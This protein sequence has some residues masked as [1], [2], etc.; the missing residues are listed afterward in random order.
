MPP[1]ALP[2]VCS[3]PVNNILVFAIVRFKERIVVAAF[4][5]HPAIFINAFC[6]SCPAL[7]NSLLPIANEPRMRIT[8]GFSLSINCKAFKI[9]SSKNLKPSAKRWCP[10]VIF[11]SCAVIDFSFLSI[12]SNCIATCWSPNPRDDVEISKACR[13]S[14]KSSIAPALF[15]WNLPPDIPLS[16]PSIFSLVV[17]ACIIKSTR[18]SSTALNSFLPFSPILYTCTPIRSSSPI[19][20]SEWIEPKIDFKALPISPP[21]AIVLRAITDISACAEWNDTPTSFADCAIRL[22]ASTNVLALTV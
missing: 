8:A 9:T 19:A 17:C 2:A 11:S 7:N 18:T 3:I 4:D 5:A 13:Y 15:H 1:P 22:L 21:S 12:V 6:P 20:L 16:N 14:F 10:L